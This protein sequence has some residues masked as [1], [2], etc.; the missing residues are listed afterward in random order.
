MPDPDCHGPLGPGRSHASQVR[1][2][3]FYR[4]VRNVSRTSCQGPGR[5]NLPPVESHPYQPL[6]GA[7]L[8]ISTSPSWQNGTEESQREAP[9]QTPATQCATVIYSVFSNPHG[10]GT[11]GG[12]SGPAPGFARWDRRVWLG[13]T[14]IHPIGKRPAERHD[15]RSWK[16]GHLDPSANRPPCRGDPN[17]NGTLTTAPPPAW[18]WL[19]PS[20]PARAPPKHV[21][22]HRRGGTCQSRPPRGLTP[23]GPSQ[24]ILRTFY[25]PGAPDGAGTATAGDWSEIRHRRP[26][27]FQ[28][29]SVELAARQ[30]RRVCQW[31]QI[32]D[33][34]LSRRG[35]VCP[36][37]LASHRLL[38]EPGAGRSRVLTPA[39]RLPVGT[40]ET[41]HRSPPL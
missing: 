30:T 11:S 26:D 4:H 3:S 24:R 38:A 29:R 36:A 33:G 14:P 31:A 16:P 32:A 6:S 22:H 28:P 37:Q 12:D 2:D 5:P 20:T 1:T 8:A 18:V 21:L 7:K 9:Q 13:R 17:D 19:T 34:A 27:Y 10:G 41:V 39:L 23:V 25:R 35:V 40:P 15:P